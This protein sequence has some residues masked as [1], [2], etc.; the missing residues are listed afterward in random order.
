[1]FLHNGRNFTPLDILSV[2]SV[3]LITKEG[4]QIMIGCM[5][6]VFVRALYTSDMQE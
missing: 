1:M 2:G 4:K 5:G 6:I 3:G